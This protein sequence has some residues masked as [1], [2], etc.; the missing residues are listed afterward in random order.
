MGDDESRISELKERMR[1][2]EARVFRLEEA[3]YSTRSAD[4][5]HRKGLLEQVAAIEQRHQI[6]PTTKECRDSA[7]QR[8]DSLG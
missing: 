3:T 5:R 1:Q 6:T 2:L 7:K 4:M 8:G